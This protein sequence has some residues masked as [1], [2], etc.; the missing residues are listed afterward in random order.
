MN[1]ANVFGRF[2]PDF[3]R[4]VAQ[5]QFDMYHHYTVDEH[6]IRAVGLLAAI[7]RGELAEDHPLSTALFR[8]IGSRRVLYVAVLLHDIAKGR[9]GDHSGLARD[10][11][12]AVPAL[13][14]RSGRDRDR[15]LA[16][17]PPPAA[18]PHR[19]Q[20]RPCRPQDDRRFRRAGAKPRA[21]AAAADPD[22]GRHPRGRP[23]H[24]DRVEA[25]ADPHA[26]R[27]CRGA[28]PARPQAARPG[29][30]DRGA[31]GAAGRV[32]SG[33]KAKRGA[34]P[35]AAA[36]RQLLAGRAAGTGSV[37]NAR[38]IAAAEAHRRR[39]SRRVVRGGAEAATRVSV[40]APDRPGLFYRICAGLAG[41]A[42]RSSMRASTPRATAWRSTICWST[43]GRGGLWR[44][45]PAAAAGQGGAAALTRPL[46]AACPRPGPFKAAFEIAPSVTVAEGASRRF[47]VVEVQAP[48][49]PGLLAALARRHLRGGLPSTRPT[50]PPMAS[51]RW[52]S[53]TWRATQA[54]ESCRQSEIARLKPALLAAAGN[55]RPNAAAACV[56]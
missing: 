17:P 43:I 26:V 54:G 29:R 21:A 49:G 45:A 34:G 32:R 48:T 12:E 2:V 40:F 37:D 52:T 20:A 9:G 28:A 42:R 30:G 16:G 50:S 56:I 23:G 3:R 55:R 15:R 18:Q 27:P 41:R 38:Q 36:A 14:A 13:R 5:M 46:P 10:R 25:A 53:S 6:T 24:L 1:E 39:P 8:Q 31:A 22:R 19:L 11:A 47:T 4:V 33:W 51:A 44:P 35:C 7:E